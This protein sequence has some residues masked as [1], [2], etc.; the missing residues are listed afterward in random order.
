MKDPA[1][2][3]SASEHMKARA[4]QLRKNSTIPERILWGLLRDRRLAGAKF[5]RKHAVG[6]YVLDFYCASHR[7]VVE[8]DGRSHHDRGFEDAERQR[9][10]QSVVGLRVLRFDNDDVL[11]DRES[12]ILGLLKALGIETV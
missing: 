3:K 11:R 12:V 8:L 5:R 6:P 10:L 9:Y 1:R 4:K 7:L 2:T